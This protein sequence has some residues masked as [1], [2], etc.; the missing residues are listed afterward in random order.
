[1]PLGE[2]SIQSGA[3]PDTEDSANAAALA[4]RH[5]QF[6]YRESNFTSSTECTLGPFGAEEVFRVEYTGSIFAFLLFRFYVGKQISFQAYSK[7]FVASRNSSTNSSNN[8]AVGDQGCMAYG[9]P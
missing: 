6:N 3:C 2:T 9:I 5:A 1:M 4:R 7:H 8:G